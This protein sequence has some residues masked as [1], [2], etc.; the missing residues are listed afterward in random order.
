MKRLINTAALL[1]AGIALIAQNNMAK[2]IANGKYDAKKPS[3]IIAMKGGE[4]YA[5]LSADGKKIT[6]LSFKTGKEEKVLFEADKT[7]NVKLKS[8]EGFSFCP[9]EKKML[10]YTNAEKVYAKSFLAEYYVFDIDRNRLDALSDSIGKQ[11]D[12]LFSPN[13]QNVVFARGNNL[14][15][16]KL[17]YETESSVTKPNEFLVSGITDWLYE[18]AFCTTNLITW[19]PD[20]R[21]I[22]YVALDEK[23]VAS[24]SFDI[25]GQNIY[26][27]NFSLKYP[28]AGT[29][30]PK[31]TVYLFDAYYK[32]TKKVDLP[33]EDFY[34]PR[35]QWTTDAENVVIF[36]LNRN[37]DQ[38]KMYSVNCKSMIAKVLLTETAKDYFDYK[39]LDFVQFLNDGKFTFA[40]KKDGF[41]QLYLYNANG[42]LNKQLTSGKYDVTGFY[43]YDS[44]KK[45]IYFQAAGVSP[46]GREIYS[47]D[48]KGKQTRITNDKGGVACGNFGDNYAYFVKK[49]STANTAPV[50]SICSTSGKEIKILEDNSDL[51][52]QIAALPKKEFV[53]INNIAAWIVKPTNFTETAKYP[54]IVMQAYVSD[55]FKIGIEQL[56]ADNG[57]VVI[58]IDSKNLAQASNDIVS[59]T[60]HAISLSYIDKNKI[61]IY[62]DDYAASAALLAM[63]NGEN[64]LKAGAVVAPVTDY[65]LAASASIE[66]QLKRPQENA[67]GY[68]NSPIASAAKLNGKLL[69]LQGTADKEVQIQQTYAY[70]NA[71][72]QADK[73]F[74]MQIYPD[75]EHKFDA[76]TQAHAYQRILNFFMENLK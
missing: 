66:R 44:I 51:T 76:K 37:Q 4:S 73:Q 30:N 39:N 75:Q 21:Q 27:Q 2:D 16:K 62:A 1:F 67:K 24:S 61:G 33:E 8:I 10:V 25:F 29:N 5:Q 63:S 71:L 22:A 23:N 46:S 13:G 34:I 50:Y 57:F 12:P 35:I 52:Q 56:F 19:S 31:P 43:G 18:T 65:R 59:V 3:Q 14:F 64:L 74:D 58:G 11:R 38:L 49:Y 15:L 17:A 40:S 53:A 68:D 72:V 20:S 69:L 7:K 60:K 47:V 48:L 42:I 70:A 6:Q 45:L 36:T 26:P 41:R 54:L 9:Q 55:C 28:K 32:S